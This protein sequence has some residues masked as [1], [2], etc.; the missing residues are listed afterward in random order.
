MKIATYYRCRHDDVRFYKGDLREFAARLLFEEYFAVAD[1][2]NNGI[3]KAVYCFLIKRGASKLIEYIKTGKHAPLEMIAEFS[4]SSSDC[5]EHT[6]DDLL[7]RLSEY[8]N[9]YKNEDTRNL[10]G[11]E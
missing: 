4:R 11:S 6:L 9:R 3:D 10:I 5:E 8:R 2:E 1:K 7:G